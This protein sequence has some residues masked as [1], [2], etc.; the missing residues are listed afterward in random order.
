MSHSDL[1]LLMTMK[2]SYYAYGKVGQASFCS[3]FMSEINN[4]A[5]LCMFWPLS[6]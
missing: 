5:M 2:K 6:L 4:V 1:T 3:H